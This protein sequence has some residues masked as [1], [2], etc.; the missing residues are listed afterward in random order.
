MLPGAET[1]WGHLVKRSPVQV[2]E[3]GNG[4]LSYSISN[5]CSEKLIS[6]LLKPQIINH[7]GNFFPTLQE[8]ST[9][10]EPLQDLKTMLGTMNQKSQSIS[11][12]GTSPILPQSCL[13]QQDVMNSN[14]SL[15]EIASGK[16]NS[17][18]KF[19]NQ[20]LAVANT[21]KPKFEPEISANELNQ[22]TSASESNERK[23]AAGPMSLQNL[24]NQPL[25]FNQS[26]ELIQAQT[27][28][29]PMQPQLESLIYHPEQLDVPQSDSSN[30]TGF[31]PSPDVDEWKFYPSCQPLSG[32]FRSPGPQS[33]FGLQDPSTLLHEAVNPPVSLGQEIWDHQLN[34]LN[35]LSQAEQLSSFSQQDPCNFNCI[36]SIVLR[37]MSDES[38]N[39]SGI[40]SCPNIDVNNGGSAVVDPAVSS[41]I[42]DDL[43]TLKNIDFQNPSDYLIGNFSSGQDV[44]S[45]ITSVSLGDSQ[46]FSHKDLPDNS[47]GTS[48]S[49]LDFDEGSLLQ[50][51]SWQQLVPPVRTY[52]K[53]WIFFKLSNYCSRCELEVYLY[54]EAIVAYQSGKC[55]QVLYIYIFI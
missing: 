46:A 42:V 4:N 5:I 40:Y 9:K 44:Q 29:W 50:N 22:V 10:V 38:Y 26:Q 24:A 34:N 53:V 17:L 11:S 20:A 49:N 18:P 37:D 33:M 45:Q 32:M 3:N 28:L 2:P 43:C 31:L 54:C 21:E 25:F 39:Q 30:L 15:K 48:S 1:D 23:M 27:S 19:E 12:E 51:N 6:M 36:N 47:G 7:P 41:T 35:S 14:S 55:M 13:D 52:T 8:Y 16:L